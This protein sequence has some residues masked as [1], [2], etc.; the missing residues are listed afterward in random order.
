MK[1]GRERE[2]VALPL[3]AAGDA[4]CSHDSRQDADDQLDDELDSFF[5]H[6]IF[7]EL[8]LFYQELKN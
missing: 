8:W 7:Q 4:Q 6:G 3:H 5:F 2:V 1:R